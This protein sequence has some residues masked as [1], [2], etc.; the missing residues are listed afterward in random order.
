MWCRN[1]INTFP[2]C[3]RRRNQSEASELKKECWVLSFGPACVVT[4]LTTILCFSLFVIICSYVFLFVFMFY[5]YY[6]YF[7]FFHIFHIFSYFFICFVIFPMLEPGVVSI[8]LVRVLA[9]TNEW[10]LVRTPE[11][12]HPRKSILSMGHHGWQALSTSPRTHQ[13]SMFQWSPTDPHGRRRNQL[14][15]TPWK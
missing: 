12:S 13:T 8:L 15:P 14:K 10:S 1:C 2:P 6:L 4:F 9:L 11:G 3:Q 7:L 5:Y